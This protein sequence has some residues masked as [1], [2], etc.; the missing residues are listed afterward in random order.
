M[1]KP[2]LAHR[3]H[4]E[5]AALRKLASKRRALVRCQVQPAKTSRSRRLVRLGG[6]HLPF[7]NL[8]RHV[9]V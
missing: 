2:I 5:L 1:Q 8:D 4:F 3:I 6:S 9:G 7:G